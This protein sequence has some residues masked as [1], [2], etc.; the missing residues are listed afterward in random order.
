MYT[1]FDRMCP[2][3]TALANH[4]A[5]LDA[6]ERRNDAIEADA[7]RLLAGDYAPFLPENIA[8]GF[9]EIRQPMLEALAKLFA[10]GNL[11]GVGMVLQMHLNDYWT[12]S[13]KQ[14]AERLI[15]QESA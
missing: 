8:E 11:E 15:D 2:N 14:Q 7:E 13:A 5:V 6:K 9:G 4:L 3:E 1:G 10:A 12:D